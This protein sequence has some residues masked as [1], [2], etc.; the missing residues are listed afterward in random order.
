MPEEPENIQGQESPELDEVNASD[1]DG[2]DAVAQAVSNSADEVAAEPSSETPVDSADSGS[3]VETAAPA[4][5]EEPAGV[6]STAAETSPATIPFEPPDFSPAARQGDG[7]QIN[8]LDDVEL[9]VKIE[10]GR[11]EMY[12]EDVL[13]LAPGSVVVLDKAAGD[14]VDIL[15]NDRLVARGEVLVLNDNFCVRINDILS[16]TPE[17]ERER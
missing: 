2:A 16:P 13:T 4:E 7:S 14:P 5:S 10:L 11:T 15:V 3:E 12:I 17:L 9:D 6:E 8:L 1:A